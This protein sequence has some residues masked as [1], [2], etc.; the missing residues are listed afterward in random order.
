LLK[1]GVFGRLLLIR[2]AFAYPIASGSGNIRLAPELGG[3]A[4]WDVGCYAVNVATM[5]F[6]GPPDQVSATFITRT[7]EQVET[8]AVGVLTF[9]A[10]R[11]ALIDYSIDYGPRAGYELQCERGSIEVANA[12]AFGSEPARI[13]VRTVNGTRVE[14]MPPV[15]HYQR[16]VAAFAEYAQ[17]GKDSPYPLRETEISMRICTALILSARAGKSIRLTQEL[18]L[19]GW[20]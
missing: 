5:F 20:R 4:T 8:S 1:S 11:R 18:P 13:I 7:G 15:D 17:T 10:E 14:T 3:G 9:D 16:Q 12:W 6:D 19:D 2:A